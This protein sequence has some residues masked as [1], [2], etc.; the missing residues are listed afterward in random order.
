M[1]QKP[2]VQVKG[3]DFHSYSQVL[4]YEDSYLLT[5]LYL[6]NPINREAKHCTC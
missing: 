6:K 1:N 4:R 3:V 2:K 5:R